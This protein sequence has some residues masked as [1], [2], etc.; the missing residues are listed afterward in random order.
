[1]NHV[2]TVVH[3]RHHGVSIQDYLN[4]GLLFILRVDPQFYP[5][6]ALAQHKNLMGVFL[7]NIGLGRGVYDLLLPRHEIPVPQLISLPRPSGYNILGAE[8]LID[9]NLVVNE[10]PNAIER[11]LLKPFE[12]LGDELSSLLER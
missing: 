9:H 8:G 6:Y 4:C 5:V 1:M 3:S 2:G 11:G 10:L 7:P 12:V